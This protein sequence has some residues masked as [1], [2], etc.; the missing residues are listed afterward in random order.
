MATPRTRAQT[1]ERSVRAEV[2]RRA[3]RS[4]S[5][6]GS[7]VHIAGGT[8]FATSGR[9]AAWWHSEHL[10]GDFTVSATDVDRVVGYLAEL[11]GRWV[12]VR[13]ET[14][15]CGD[16]LCNVAPLQRAVPPVEPHARTRHDMSV[17]RVDLSGTRY[18]HDNG[19]VAILICDGQRVALIDRE[20]RRDL[21]RVF[22]VTPYAVA[23]DSWLLS[24]LARQLHGDL[25]EVSVHGLRSRRALI[26]LTEHGIVRTYGIEYSVV[27]ALGADNARLGSHGPLLFHAARRLRA[28]DEEVRTHSVASRPQHAPRRSVIVAFRTTCGAASR[29]VERL[30]LMEGQCNDAVYAVTVEPEAIRMQLWGSATSAI[31]VAMN[32]ECVQPGVFPVLGRA[33]RA[34]ALLPSEE[35]VEFEARGTRARGTAVQ[36]VTGGGTRVENF[37]TAADLSDGGSS[38]V[39]VDATACS[40]CGTSNGRHDLGLC[41]R[42][43]AELYAGTPGRCRSCGSRD[44]S[45]VGRDVVVECRNCSESFDWDPEWDGDP[46]GWPSW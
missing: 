41:D 46:A 44:L 4:C 6:T 8:A 22:G 1:P 19:R 40:L 24:A 11:R 23:I 10:V 15:R 17:A 2:L 36:W 29:A 7:D 43:L 26:T 25:L 5:D 45:G 33:V 14:L 27:R 3:L 39:P 42:C 32:G 16:A 34:L 38:Q 20:S 28:D 31:S 18:Q 21:A 9:F 37:F 12:E 30:A 35:V 13:E